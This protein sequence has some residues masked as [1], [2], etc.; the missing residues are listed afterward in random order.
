[1][2]IRSPGVY[3]GIYNHNGKVNTQINFSFTKKPLMLLGAKVQ[4]AGSG[5]DIFS[6]TE[7]FRN[8]RQK[9]WVVEMRRELE[10]WVKSIDLGRRTIIQCQFRTVYNLTLAGIK[11]E[12]WLRCAYERKFRSVQSG[13]K[14][15]LFN[16]RH[17]CASINFEEEDPV[18][19]RKSG[20]VQ[21]I[22]RKEDLE[23]EEMEVALAH[24]NG[25]KELGRRLLPKRHVVIS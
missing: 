25:K 23:Q 13:E 21:A 22:S 2:P 9:D 1:M 16:V 14:H 4:A 18:C 8:M 15:Y 3:L 5:Q 20:V 17:S 7:S 6:L 24:L 19:G 11:A 10:E 12:K